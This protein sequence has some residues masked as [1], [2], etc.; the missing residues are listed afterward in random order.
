MTVPQSMVNRLLS[1]GSD[2]AW[3]FARNLLSVTGSVMTSIL[4][5]VIARLRSISGSNYVFTIDSNFGTQEALGYIIGQAPN[6]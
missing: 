4:S 1:V 5:P 2:Y 6:F 3:A